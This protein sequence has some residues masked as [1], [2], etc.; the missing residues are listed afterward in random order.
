VYRRDATSDLGEDKQSLRAS[1]VLSKYADHQVRLLTHFDRPISSRAH[2]P[3]V[4]ALLFFP[5]PEAELAD[6]TELVLDFPGGGFIAMGPEC[7]EE[8]L[9]R[10]AKRLNRPVLSVEYGKAPECM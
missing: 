5:R 10:W 9:R 3:P 8:R 1:E 4:P 6:A 2:L 7:H